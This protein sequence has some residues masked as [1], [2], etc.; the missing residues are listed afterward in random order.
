MIQFKIVM[1][2]STDFIRL[3]YG[4][5]SSQVSETIQRQGGRAFVDRPESEKFKKD[6]TVANPNE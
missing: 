1:L 3:F 6:G 4:P 2:N 5:V